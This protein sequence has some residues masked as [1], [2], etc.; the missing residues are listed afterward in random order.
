MEQAGAK[1]LRGEEIGLIVEDMIKTVEEEVAAFQRLH[2]VLMNQQVSI[3]KGN[4][5][6]VSESTEEVDRL[7][8]ETKGL[9]AQWR[10]RTRDL[11]RYLETD[12]EIPLP[13]LIPL[14]EFRYA[15]RLEELREILGTLITK[16]QSTNKRNKRLLEQSMRFVERY[17][18]MLTGKG[19]HLPS[20][21]PNGR[22]A[23]PDSSVYHGLG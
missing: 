15:Q 2:D 14:V 21:G 9:E 8:H 5:V 17:I 7:V 18:N 19:G 20:Y 22:S 11:S 13:E 16:V 12:G 3:M 23:K 6:S 1:M 10:G 4:P